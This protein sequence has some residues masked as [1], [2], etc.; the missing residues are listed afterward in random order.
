MESVIRMQHVTKRYGR[1]FA[2]NDVSL[3][4]PPGVVLALLPTAAGVL[5][6]SG[7]LG[8]RDSDDHHRASRRSRAGDKRDFLLRSPIRGTLR[9]RMRRHALR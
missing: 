5:D 1:E 4:V 3:E 7:G 2:L 6:L 8:D 9:A